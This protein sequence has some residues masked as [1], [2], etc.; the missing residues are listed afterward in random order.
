MSRRDQAWARTLWAAM[1]AEHRW[2][3]RT[4]E[5]VMFDWPDGKK[6]RYHQSPPAFFAIADEQGTVDEREYLD[7]QSALVRLAEEQSRRGR[8][9]H[10]KVRCAEPRFAPGP[11]AREDVETA[12]Q[13]VMATVHPAVVRQEQIMRCAFVARLPQQVRMQIGTLSANLH[14]ELPT[15]S[16]EYQRK[17]NRT[18]RARMDLGFGHPTVRE[19]IAGVLEL[20]RLTAFS[21]IWFRKQV[22]KLT[23][24]HAGLMFSGLAGDFQKLLDPKLPT[25]A[26]RLSWAVTKT[27]GV[28]T[29]KDVAASARRLLEPV[30]RRLSR[31][32]CQE[33]YEESTQSLRWEWRDG[34]VLNLAWYWPKSNA[35]DEFEPVW[36]AGL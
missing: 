20:K 3:G 33:T 13:S 10:G 22:D 35:P 2:S 4:F 26:F 32:G 1:I 21:E 18:M 23:S 34:V 14:P 31:A 15:P 27:R 6:T 17:G 29:P 8:T 16:S 7:L 24:T 36:M 19:Q 9:R 30:E 25:E 11:L 28:M 5:R 12:I